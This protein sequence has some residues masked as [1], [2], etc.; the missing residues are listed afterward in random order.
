LDVSIKNGE[1][2]RKTDNERIDAIIASSGGE[3]RAALKYT[4][5]EN[6]L[7]W[8][9]F[10][11]FSARE[12]DA[13]VGIR[14]TCESM[15]TATR[16]PAAKKPIIVRSLLRDLGGGVDGGLLVQE[17]PL[18]LKNGEIDL[19]ARLIVGEVECH[20]PIVYTSYGFDGDYSVDPMSLANKL[21]G[22]AHVVVEPNR[23][24]SRRL[25]IEVGSENVYGGTV[26]VYWPSGGGR[27]SFFLGGENPTPKA[28][29]R[30][31]VEEVR[32][33]LLNRR[34]LV[35]CTWSSAQE[36]LSR[37]VYEALKNAGSREVEKYINAFDLE[38][39]AKNEKL[40]DAENEILRLQ[41][42]L[43][44]YESRMSEGGAVS[45]KAG[46]EQDL[47]PGELLDIVI[48]AMVG[49]IDRVQPDSRR[50][51][52]LR[53]MCNSNP[54]TGETGRRKEFL[55]ELL[56]DYRSMDG[57]TKGGLKN[58]GFSIEED[59]KHYKLVYQGDDRYIF[60]LPKSGSDRRGGLNCASDIAKRIF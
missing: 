19:A 38:M 1:W 31:I 8:D 22:M 7:Q 51:H 55:K 12:V 26:G 5:V 11:V 14:V 44:K 45:L 3:E 25:Q 20:L 21:S 53:A 57:K 15:Q 33:A 13:W 18:F 42:E 10:V 58:L 48:D 54:G 30:A 37:S 47:Y 32:T 34:P 43:R 59:G 60:P 50:Q 17:A 29:E 23:P 35:R 46:E 41:S 16:L 39:K 9:T 24:F 27:R 36:A 28:L 49:S 6:D 4:I 2:W 52:V 56:R 40:E